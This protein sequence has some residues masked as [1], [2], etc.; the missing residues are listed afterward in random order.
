MNGH[1][2]FPI[3]NEYAELKNISL[4]FQLSK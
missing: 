3:N 1:Y 4:E 2:I